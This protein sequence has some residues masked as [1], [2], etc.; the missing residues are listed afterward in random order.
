MLFVKIEEELLHVNVYQTILVIH[1]L[2]VGQNVQ[3]MQNAHLPKHVKTFIVLT[4]VQLQDVVLMLNV[5][6][7]ITYQ[8]V[9]V[10]KDI[11]EILSLHADSHHWL[12]NQ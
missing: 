1:M 2:P 7:L 11:L 8:T 9:F 6:L 5:K 10:S 12:L 3:Q 4:H